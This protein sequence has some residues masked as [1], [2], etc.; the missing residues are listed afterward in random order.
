MEALNE[1]MQR[2]EVQEQ[3]KEVQSLMQDKDFAA[4]IE[5]LRVC[6]LYHADSV[7][8]HQPLT[9]ASCCLRTACYSTTLLHASTHSDAAAL[10]LMQIVRRLFCCLC[11]YTNHDVMPC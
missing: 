7:K 5:K 10:S 6:M 2:P 4:K 1:Q 11:I 9:E 8:M 3:M